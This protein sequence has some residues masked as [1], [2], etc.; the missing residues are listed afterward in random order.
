MPVPTI[1]KKEQEQNNLAPKRKKLTVDSATVDTFERCK[2]KHQQINTHLK[3]QNKEISFHL[4]KDI[5]R[6][7]KTLGKKYERALDEIMD[8]YQLSAEQNQADS[9]DSFV[10]KSDFFNPE[11]VD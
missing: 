11:K 9:Q 3:E 2:T 6:S 4:E 5:E 7:L 1:K 10:M 8:Q